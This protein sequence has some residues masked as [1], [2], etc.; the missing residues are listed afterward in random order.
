L[1]LQPTLVFVVDMRGFVTRRQTWL[2]DAGHTTPSIFHRYALMSAN[3]WSP[4]ELF[5]TGI[6]LLVLLYSL[7]FSSW[8]ACKGKSWIWFWRTCALLIGSG[9]VIAL[10]SDRPA[11]DYTAEMPKEFAIGVV[12]MLTG[13]VF[14]LSGSLLKLFVM[15]RKRHA[16]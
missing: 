6:C 8:Q 10:Y 5:N 1:I 16:A 11:A 4:I 13:I 2:R 3:D 7:L 9:I 14:T 12:I 15:L